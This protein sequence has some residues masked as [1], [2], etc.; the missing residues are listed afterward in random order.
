VL[1]GDK[2]LVGEEVLSDEIVANEEAF[3]EKF[4]GGRTADD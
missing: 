2:A 3:H 1:T 4:G